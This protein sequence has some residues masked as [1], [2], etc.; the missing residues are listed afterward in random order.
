MAT[1]VQQVGGDIALARAIGVLQEVGIDVDLTT[2]SK[3]DD[4]I[5]LLVVLGNVWQWVS[6]TFSSVV[7][8]LYDHIILPISR[9]FDAPVLKRLRQKG[10]SPI[11]M[12]VGEGGSGV[13]ALLQMLVTVGTLKEVLRGF[14]SL[15]FAFQRM[16][17]FGQAV[18][19]KR[20]SRV[21][22]ESLTDYELVKLIYRLQSVVVELEDDSD[23]ELRGA[24]CRGE[25][26]VG[27]LNMKAVLAE[28]KDPLVQVR[29][30]EHLSAVKQLDLFFEQHKIAQSNEG[31]V[32]SPQ[33][34]KVL[35][36][37]GADGLLKGRDL[38]EAF[39][40]M[41]EAAPI[42]TRS[43]GFLVDKCSCKET[44][45]TYVQRESVNVVRSSEYGENS[46][47]YH[48]NRFDSLVSVHG[49]GTVSA[50]NTAGCNPLEQYT[51]VSERRT[52]Y[53]PLCIPRDVDTSL[54]GILEGYARPVLNNQPTYKSKEGIYHEFREHSRVRF[55]SHPP[56]RMFLSLDRASRPLFDDR[57]LEIPMEKMVL[58]KKL[59]SEES[60]YYLT[61]FIAYVGK[62]YAFYR[63]V[64][65]EWYEVVNQKV[66]GV[67]KKEVTEILNRRAVLL[68]YSV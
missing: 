39:R 52:S 19:D 46:F 61:A 20:A 45:K 1:L 42:P 59:S 30:I 25:S 31:Y 43:S 38:T 14:G 22:E 29:V 33:I 62:E 32:M 7:V 3:A 68:H 55:F 27:A 49:I 53:L 2:Y 10:E 44:G 47:D 37:L 57:P 28:L 12:E 5:Y 21:P 17:E 60:H 50:S 51:V 41:M 13:T 67:T 9:I 58:P 40:C 54:C 34:D 65:G 64:D 63:Q 66:R 8:S 48:N 18:R 56:R 24:F 16:P 4:R 15:L 35:S 36:L 11:G 23:G 26:F 6:D